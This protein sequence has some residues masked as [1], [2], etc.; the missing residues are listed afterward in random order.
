[1]I[2]WVQRGSASELS[3]SVTDPASAIPRVACFTSRAHLVNFLPTDTA[4]AFE[5]GHS[6][7]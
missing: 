6:E 2:V 3:M 5:R 1:M 4:G 7:E